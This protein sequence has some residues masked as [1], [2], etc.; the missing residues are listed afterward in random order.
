MV[1]F[2]G[3]AYR[4]KVD[5]I[6]CEAGLIQYSWESDSQRQGDLAKHHEHTIQ[7]PDFSMDKF[8]V[9]NYDY[10]SFLAATGYIPHDMTN[11]LKDWKHNR[12]G[13]LELRPNHNL[14][15]VTWVN[16]QEAKEY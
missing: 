2:K 3:I 12:N 14:K 8:P 1:R 11:W 16:F 5:V 15:P 6:S 10:S 13:T 4:Y 9:T 7:L